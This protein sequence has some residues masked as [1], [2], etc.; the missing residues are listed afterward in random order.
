MSKYARAR[1]GQPFKMPAEIY[2]RMLDVIEH[3]GE[4]RM[5]GRGRAPV[6]GRDRGL[7]L[8]K[9]ASGYD[10][11]R[12]AVLGI[13]GIA[14]VSDPA[15]SAIAFQNE[16]VLSGKTPAS[17]HAGKFVVLAEAVRNGAV[18]WGVAS[19]VVPCKVDLTYSGQPY[20]DVASGSRAK[21]AAGEGGAAQVLWHAGTTGEQWALV[22]L[23]IPHYPILYGTLAADTTSSPTNVTVGSET[24]SAKLRMLPASG[25]KYATNTGVYL[26]HTPDGWEIISVLGCTVDAS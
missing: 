21:L 5:A 23:G 6:G 11:G 4:L 12:F 13:D 9:N 15:S 16:H 25:K 19:G 20:A 10:C 22:R 18:G 14:A 2:N 8:V 24:I 3:V 26:G 1:A 17:S 7:V